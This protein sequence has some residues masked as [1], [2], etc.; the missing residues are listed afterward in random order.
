MLMC[1]CMLTKRAQILFGNDLWNRIDKLATAKKISAG[2]LIRE[3]VEKEL[4]Q[5]EII[6]QR[7]QAFEHIL[8]IRPKPVKGKI[9]Y[10]E[11][12]NYGREY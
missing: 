9:N 1:M 8:K 5:E 6:L 2:Q 7:R 10:K 11:L 4:S 3:A 12:I